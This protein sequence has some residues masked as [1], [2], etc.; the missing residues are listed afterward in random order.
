MQYLDTFVLVALLCREPRS[1]DVLTWLYR[2]ETGPVAISKWTLVEFASALSLKLRTHSIA[3]TD[4]DRAR[5]MLGDMLQNMLMA[6]PLTDRDF[7][8]AAEFCAFWHLNLRGPDALH[9]AIASRLNLS[10]ATFDRVQ[11]VAAQH[12]DIPATIP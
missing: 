8:D 9:L 3:E 5:A 4:A 1:E 6:L 2:P 7:H 12:F 10:L 11:F